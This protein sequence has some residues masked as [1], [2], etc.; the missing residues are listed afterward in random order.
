MSFFGSMV[1]YVALP[2]QAYQIS[3]SSLIV[4]L[5]SLAELVPLLIT[6]FIGGALADAVD[7]RRMVRITE[8]AMCLV[9]GV[10]VVN[11]PSRPPSPVG[12]VRGRLRCCGHRRVA[13]AI[14]R[15]DGAAAGLART[16]ARGVGNHRPFGAVSG[17]SA[18]PPVAGVL[19]VVA[20][21]PLTYGLDVATYFVSLVALALMRAAASAGESEGCLF[22][23]SDGLRYAR[24]RKDLL[25]SYLVD[26]NAM[27]FGIPT[28]LFPRS[29]RHFG[30]AGVL[31]FS[32]LR[33]RWARCS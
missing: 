23:R 26:M 30:G 32:T 1:T 27:F 10:L 17:W 6:A 20:G 9:I 29:P 19:I 28:A 5:L 15:R 11:S 14:A 7:R 21:L 12:A 22:G 31:G 16:A 13:A 3:H 33:R 8:S 4:G 24:S 18:G 2:Y 25:G